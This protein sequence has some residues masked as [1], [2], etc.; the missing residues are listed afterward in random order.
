[1]PSRATTQHF[2][3]E[4]AAEIRKKSPTSLKVA[5]G[6]MQRGR[7]DELG[8]RAEARIPAWPPTLIGSHDYREGVAARIAGNGRAPDWQPGD[9]SPTSMT[10]RSSA[11]SRPQPRTSSSSRNVTP[12]L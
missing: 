1:M 6:Q 11:C 9:A 5:F 3:R 2:A 4:T 10:R 8:D 12:G 7:L